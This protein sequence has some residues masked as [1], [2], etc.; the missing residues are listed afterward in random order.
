MGLHDGRQWS[1]LPAPCP[2]VQT[3]AGLWHPV[4]SGVVH[5]L[6]EAVAEFRQR[7]LDRGVCLETLVASDVLQCEYPGADFAQGTADGLAALDV[8]GCLAPFR[9]GDGCP[10]TGRRSV[11]VVDTR[12]LPVINVGNIAHRDRLAMR[13]G[14]V[15]GDFLVVF[16]AEAKVHEVEQAEFCQAA[17][18]EHRRACERSACQRL[19]PFLRRDSN[20]ENCACCFATSPSANATYRWVIKREVC[21]S[22]R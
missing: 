8:L 9:V 12:P 14:V 22:I 19:P 16:D 1:V 11:E 4:V 10:L 21:P 17:P 18:G 5:P 3:N 2:Q 7:C 13:L 6:I 20:G 15:G